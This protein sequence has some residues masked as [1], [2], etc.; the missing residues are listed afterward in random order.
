MRVMNDESG[1][2]LTTSALWS[3]NYGPVGMVGRTESAA[4]IW[5][6]AKR[7]VPQAGAAGQRTR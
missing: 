4:A 6:T 1:K 5:W 7:N 3:V 2:K